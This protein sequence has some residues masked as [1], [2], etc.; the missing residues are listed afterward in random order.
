MVPYHRNWV[1][2]AQEKGLETVRTKQKSCRAVFCCGRPG[3][4][5]VNIRGSGP[6]EEGIES[7]GIFELWHCSLHPAEI[8]SV[9]LP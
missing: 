4:V 7:I 1:R 6:E 5:G 8:S 9:K 2:Q 3:L